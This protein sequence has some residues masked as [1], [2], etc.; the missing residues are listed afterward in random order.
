[1]KRI[2][3][4]HVLA[5]HLVGERTRFT[6]R[7]RIGELSNP[8]YMTGTSS[9]RSIGG[10]RKVVGGKV[11]GGICIC[12]P[13]NELGANVPG[14][15]GI[16]P[17]IIGIDP[18]NGSDPGGS[19]P[20]IIGMDPGNGT[21]PGGID[22]CIIGIDPGNGTDPGGICA[23]WNELGPWEAPNGRDPGIIGNDPWKEP[24][25]AVGGGPWKDP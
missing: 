12:A 7:I 19:D 24:K 13:W 8:A 18:G 2:N 9:G 21:D 25:G 17:A 3:D 14:G 22:P 23:P 4:V 15:K 5:H 6:S 1:M 11:P 20:G 16:D 10:S